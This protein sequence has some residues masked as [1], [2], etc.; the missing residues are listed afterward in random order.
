MTVSAT[1]TLFEML[2]KDLSLLLA[3]DPWHLVIV[4]E[5]VRLCF[6]RKTHISSIHILMLVKCV[7]IRSLMTTM[8]LSREGRILFLHQSSLSFNLPSPTR[9]HVLTAM[10]VL[11][12]MLI[13]LRIILTFNLGSPWLKHFALS[14]SMIAFVRCLRFLT[15]VDANCDGNYDHDK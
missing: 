8:V 14:F 13:L 10:M 3:G 11:F 6:N 15:R 12:F 1:G 4:L 7:M 2:L 5:V 9:C